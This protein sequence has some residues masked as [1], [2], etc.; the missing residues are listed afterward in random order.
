[1]LDSLSGLLFGFTITFQLENL[2]FCFAG[3]FV[4]TLIGVL[5]GIGPSGALAILLPATFYLSPST[6]VIMLA[7]IYYGA[8]YGGST[9]S[10]LINIPGEAASVV[11]CLDGYQMARKGRAGPALGIA[12]IGSFIAGTSGVI[13]LMFLAPPLANFA[14]KFSSPEYA[15]IIIC[16]LILVS[17]LGSGSIWKAF[18]MGAFGLLLGTIG[19]DPM[20]RLDRFTFGSFYLLEGLGLIPII[21]GLF[22]ISEILINLEEEEFR[23]IL[24]EKIK[25]LFPNRRDWIDSTWPILRGTV[26]GFFVGIIPGG[27]TIISATMSY[28]VEKKVSKQ[29][30]K[31]GTGAIEGVAGPESANN[32]SVTGSFIP[33]LSLGIPTNA[34]MAL[35]L[36]SLMLHGVSP[37]PLLISQHPE[38]FWSVIASM[39]IGNLMLLALNLPLIGLWVKLLKIPYAYLFPFIFLFCLLGTYS[40]R[41]TVFD[42]GVMI[43]FGIVGYLMRKFAYEPAPFILAFILGPMFEEHFRRSLIMSYGSFTIFFE[44]P[45][46]LVFMFAAILLLL[47]SLVPWIKGKKGFLLKE[48]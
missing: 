18:I 39:Y 13:G 25:N 41:N 2:F 7:G 3:C 46:S 24:Q 10:I 1:M 28:A 33:L 45:I 20:D 26:I 36:A 6:A 29:P 23:G 38:I 21:M 47:S 43:L 22:G 15:S 42:I 31:F 30:E 27:N 14:L 40:L 37:G 17:Y 44:R 8:M 11:T 5:P 9:T 4:G 48:S 35:L 19:S 32:S 16:G 34:V 12:A